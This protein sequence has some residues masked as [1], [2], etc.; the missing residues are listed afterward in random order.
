MNHFIVW[1][2]GH[3]LA[4]IS[5]SILCTYQCKVFS[6]ARTVAQTKWPVHKGTWPESEY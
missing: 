6:Y 1:V 2:Q 5:Q 4:S 3:A